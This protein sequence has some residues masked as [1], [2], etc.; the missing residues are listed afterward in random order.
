MW[1]DTSKRFD[2]GRFVSSNLLRFEPDL[3]QDQID[4]WKTKMFEP[5]GLYPADLGEKLSASLD[6]SKII[7]LS[8]V[9]PLNHSFYIEVRGATPNSVGEAWFHQRRLDLRGRL[10]EALRMDVPAD[11]HKMGRGR[12]L[13]AD[14]IDTALDMKMRQID[15]EAEKIG[16][17]VWARMGFVPE[18]S[19]WRNL[20]LEARR[21]LRMSEHEL[22]PEVFRNYRDA[23]DVEDPK[24]IWE[25]S[26][27]PELVDSREALV[28]SKPE[29]IAIGKALLLET[30]ANWY[31][32]FDL[33]DPEALK[34]FESYV[35]RR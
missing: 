25:V 9:S 15:I 31:G 26:A 20:Q 10:F 3:T 5:Y 11:D 28:R 2:A 21:R 1:D 22:P 12:H 27:W 14:L 18:R 29:K 13:M 8:R 33:E 23:L 16:R 6:E 17:Y 30:P 19:A 34:V 35:G 32:S 4:W 24:M 7:T